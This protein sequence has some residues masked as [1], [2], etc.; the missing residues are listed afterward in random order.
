MNFRSSV[1]VP[2]D[3]PKYKTTMVKEIPVSTSEQWK[4]WIRQCYFNLFGLKSEQVIIDF[5]TDSGTN[6]MSDKQW[7][8]MFLGDES[9]AG[10]SSF[11][12]LK[13]TVEQLTGFP[14]LIPA[15]QGRAAEKL[16]FPLI[17]HPGDLIP[18]NLLFDT[19]AGHIYLS[20][21][22]AI[23][24]ITEEA[25]NISSLYPFKGN[26]DINK[27]K[28]AL[29]KNSEKIPCIVVT[30]TCNSAGGQPVSM[31]NLREV[32]AISKKY[33]KSVIFDSARFAENAYFIQK[34]EEGYAERSIKKIVYEMFQYT[35]IMTMSAKKDASVNIGGFIAL[36]DEVLYKKLLP[37]TIIYEGFYEYGGMA[38]RD[39]EAI[40]QGLMENTNTD[41]YLG[42]RIKQVQYLGNLLTCAGIPIQQPPGGHA[43]YIN[44]KDFFYHIPREQFPAQTLAIELYKLAGVRGAEIGNLVQDRK[45]DGSYTFPLFD[46]L[47]LA[48]PRRVYG[49]E[50]I[51]Y[52][53][54][55][56]IHLFQNRETI[57]TGYRII[58]EEH[59]MR[60]FTVKLE[61]V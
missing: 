42:D 30:I 13:E 11:K 19:T 40:A 44:G 37:Q 47:R 18:T 61:K 15:H 39:M 60:H 46:W 6:A 36:R 22:K 50:H 52:V 23:D 55:A 8:S 14:Y 9:Y 24:C 26:L 1:W 5:L 25:S 21:G 17:I 2:P 45:S 3:I 38:G 20:G 57:S 35:D 31:E 43:I 49:Q 7:S 10:S 34:R 53:A 59:C 56:L 12:K 4:K 29:E 16:L 27:L 32:Y 54:S 48:I 33:G 58:E 28:E 51:E 41:P